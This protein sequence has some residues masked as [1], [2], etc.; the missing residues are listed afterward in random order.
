MSLILEA[1]RKSEAERQAASLPGLI[2][3]PESF[4]GGARRRW[5]W[6]WW[7]PLVL[8]LG[9]ALGWWLPRWLDEPTQPAPAADSPAPPES[10]PSGS[11]LAAPAS[12]A[13]PR[14]RELAKHAE[15]LTPPPPAPTTAPASAPASAT[16]PTVQSTP[17]ASPPPIAA[18][19]QADNPAASASETTPDAARLAL[20]PSAQRQL[21][22]A[23]KLSVHVFNPDPAR[24]FAI[25][26]GRRVVDG[27]A[28]GQGVTLREIRRD[29]LLLDVN[30]QPWLLER[31]Q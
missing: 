20:M 9:L 14:A 17:A 5:N 16:P 12:P 3:T 23:L 10:E 4:R 29:G 11:D 30:G 27:D 13:N 18:P 6:L 31:G 22:P 8:L 19:P 24:R 25:V 28:L 21:L 7:L 15:Q 1:L 26:D 2:G